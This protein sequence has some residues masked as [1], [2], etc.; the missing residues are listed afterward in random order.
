AEL[1]LVIFFF[2]EF[3]FAPLCC[4]FSVRSAFLVGEKL[5]L[6]DRVI[7]RLLVLVDLSLVEQALQHPLDTFF[8]W[9]IGCGCPGVVAN[10]E[11]V[12][13]RDELLG[14]AGDELLWRHT[15]FFSPYFDT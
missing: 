4:E 9:W 7:T 12:P 3:H 11:L 15:L 10:I 2:A 6:P 8:V 1:E 14:N 13:K 5:F